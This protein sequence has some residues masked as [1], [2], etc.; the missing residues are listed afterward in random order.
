M[1][2]AVTSGVDA[3]LLASSDPLPRGS[4]WAPGLGLHLVFCL[5]KNVL[6]Q[7]VLAHTYKLRT[8]VLT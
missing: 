4:C 3:G 5:Y 7:H 1:T 8:R 6:W 2:G